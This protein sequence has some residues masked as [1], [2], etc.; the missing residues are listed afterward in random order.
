MRG[1]SMTI[2]KAVNKYLKDNKDKHLQEQINDPAR[3]DFFK[4]LNNKI[5]KLIEEGEEIHKSEVGFLF[6][7]L[8]IVLNKHIPALPKIYLQKEKTVLISDNLIYNPRKNIN[9]VGLIIKKIELLFREQELKKE[10]EKEE[11]KEVV[12]TD[13]DIINEFFN[14]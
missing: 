11:E 6:Y 5:D 4:L 9:E 12:K 7:P 14:V 8:G 3:S 2:E 13:D 10:K 1:D